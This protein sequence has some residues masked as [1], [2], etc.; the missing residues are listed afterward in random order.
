MAIDVEEY[1]RVYGPMVMRR[2][3]HLLKNDELALDAMQDVFVELVRRQDRLDLDKPSS[4]LYRTATNVC[5]NKIR[6]ARRKP[7]EYDNDL[8]ERIATTP[9]SDGKV[10]ARNFLNKLFS[11]E[12]VSTKEMAVMHLLDG[13]T[14]QEVADEFK[15]SVSGVRKRLRVLKAHLVELEG[16]EL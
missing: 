16:S 13:A 8:L 3:R 15:M 6:S 7:A 1:Y 14:L 2:C 12:Q 5:L 4:F 11:N 10:T 9:D